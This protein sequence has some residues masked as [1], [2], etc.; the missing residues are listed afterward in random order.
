MILLESIDSLVVKTLLIKIWLDHV[1]NYGLWWFV[2]INKLTII[3]VYE[4][5]S[6]RLSGIE[7][8]D[9]SWILRIYSRTNLG[10]GRNLRNFIIICLLKALISLISLIF[11]IK[12]KMRREVEVILDSSIW[13]LLPILIR[14]ELNCIG[15]SWVVSL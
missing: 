7:W 15:I 11:Q 2:Y 10:I 1:I 12:N 9:S 5:I 14:K 8:R 13:E 3:L 4:S 6:F